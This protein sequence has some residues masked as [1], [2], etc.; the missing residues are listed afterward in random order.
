MKKRACDVFVDILREYEIEYV[1]GI[2][3]ATEIY[4]MDALER[5]SDIKY[6]LGLNELT[7]VSMAE[8]YARTTGKPAV[9]NMH[10]VYG[11][12]AALPLLINCKQAHAPVVVT[13]GDTDQRLLNSD[14]QL[15]GKIVDMGE[16]VAKYSVGLNTS[17]ELPRVLHR[18]I[19]R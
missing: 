10:T 8:G 1:Y 14:P 11:M 15:T 6:I 12:A 2:P 4:F 16:T 7:C 9:L 3:G 19:K 13:V 5:Q 17:E 18:A